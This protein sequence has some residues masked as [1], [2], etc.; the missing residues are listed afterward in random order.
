MHLLDVNVWLALAFGS[1]VHHLAAKKWFDDSVP[2]K[3]YFCRATQM[4][5]LRLATNAKAFPQDAVSMSRAWAMYDLMIADL[6]IE[7]AEEP[8]DVLAIWRRNTQGTSFSPKVWMDAY[9]AAF[10]ESADLQVV[11]FDQAF[12]HFASARTTILK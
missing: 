12:R 2:D 10:A 7:Y 5:F 3:C 4:G 8:V 1:H 6:R 11:T 9:L